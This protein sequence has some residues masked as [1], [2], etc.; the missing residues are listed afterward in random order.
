MERTRVVGKKNSNECV[1]MASGAT[2]FYSLSLPFSI[3]LCAILDAIVLSRVVNEIKYST[4]M[5]TFASI[6][7]NNKYIF[8]VWLR[9]RRTDQF[10]V[11]TAQRIAQRGEKE[12]ESKRLQVQAKLMATFSR[13]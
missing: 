6:H 5:L 8:S 4:D 13:C 7:N 2:I 1:K 10:F 9:R 11:R 12:R 3:S